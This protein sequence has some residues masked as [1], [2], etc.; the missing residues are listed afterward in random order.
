MKVNIAIDGPVASG[1]STI[2]KMV[3]KRLGYVHIDTGA[4][5]RT[6]AYFAKRNDI[7]VD[8]KDRLV[9]LAK[10]LNIELTADERVIANGEDVTTAIRDQEIS[11]DASKVSVF[12][13]VRAIMVSY[14]QKLATSLGVVMDGR[15]IGTVVL[16]NAQ[17]KIFQTASVESRAKRRLNEYLV[18]GIQVDL[19]TVKKE[20]SDRD[21]VDTNRLVSP[22]KKADDAIEIDT[23]TCSI[24]EVVDQICMIVDKV[25]KQRD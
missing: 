24:D 11:T 5:Y 13:E 25:V 22:L 17:V 15:D 18:K 2:A 19:E 10:S 3:A 23:S 14:Q 7:A 4:M 21:F 8:D 20:I 9:D 6:L 16:P 1:K 12:S